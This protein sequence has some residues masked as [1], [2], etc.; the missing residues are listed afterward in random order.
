M[1]LV[2]DEDNRY[3]DGIYFGKVSAFLYGKNAALKRYH[4]IHQPQ[5]LYLDPILEKA[6]NIEKMDLR[7]TSAEPE[8]D[9][10]RMTFAYRFPLENLKLRVS[11]GSPQGAYLIKWVLY[12]SDY[13]VVQRFQAVHDQIRESQTERNGEKLVR[14]E[15]PMLLV[16]GTYILALRIEDLHSDRLGVY[17]KHFSTKLKEPLE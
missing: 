11:Q 14:G 5:F 4:F 3:K 2:S 10:I 13:E 1:L 16:P 12:D 7:I 15:I 17:R 9:Q 8:G 6:R